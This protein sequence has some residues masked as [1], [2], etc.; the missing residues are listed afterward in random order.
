MLVN[1]TIIKNNKDIDISNYVL[2][3]IEIYNRVDLISKI[4]NMFDD[5]NRNVVIYDND[6]LNY[7]VSLLSLNSDMDKIKIYMSLISMYGY[8][9][10][11]TLITLFSKL[12]YIEDNNEY[13][14]K[15]NEIKFEIFK[16]YSMSRINNNQLEN[17]VDKVFSSMFI[18]SRNILIN[19]NEYYILDYLLI[20]SKNNDVINELYNNKK[21]IN[22]DYFNSGE[23]IN[24][25]LK[26]KNI[27]KDDI[28]LSNFIKDIINK[29][30]INKD[31]F[32]DIKY[33]NLINKIGC[34]LKYDDDF[35][36][37]I[38]NHIM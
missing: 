26:N 8:L 33:K 30:D 36:V 35:L 32:I 25:I 24:S 19:K 5:C 3:N 34:N 20:L 14:N 31:F 23:F 21:S 2:N 7:M 11:D 28:K 29:L 17:Q 12:K 9:K 1:K 15:L 4:S 6:L 27:I 37:D 22:F 10:S 13:N 18:S 16:M 38:Y